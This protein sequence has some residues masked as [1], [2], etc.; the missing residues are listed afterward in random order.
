MSSALVARFVVKATLVPPARTTLEPFALPGPQPRETWRGEHGAWKAGLSRLQT[1]SGLQAADAQRFR[2][3]GLGEGEPFRLELSFAGPASE[4]GEPTPGTWLLEDLKIV[5]PAGVACA[6]VPE[7][8]LSAPWAARFAVPRTALASDQTLSVWL[9]GRSPSD[10]AAL[11][12][13]GEGPT[14]L[15]VPLTAE[16]VPAGDLSAHTRLRNL[17]R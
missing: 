9:W 8:V 7:G 3:L 1:D 14:N 16:F 15:R 4:A 12:I 17:S 6:P 5:D 11:E 13:Q 2:A 10:E